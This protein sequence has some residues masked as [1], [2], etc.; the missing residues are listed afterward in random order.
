MAHH[1]CR[2]L[3]DPDGKCRLQIGIH[4]SP[5]SHVISSSDSITKRGSQKTCVVGRTGSI[6]TQEG[7]IP[8]QSS[9][10]SSRFFGDFLFSSQKDGRMAPNYKPEASQ[11]FY[12]AQTFP[13]GDFS[14]CPQVANQKYLGDFHRPP[15]R[16]FTHPYS[17]TT[18]EVASFHDLR[19]GLR[20]PLSPFWS[21][22][23]PQSFHKGGHVHSSLSPEAGGVNSCLPRRLVDYRSHLS[24]GGAAHQ[25]GHTNDGALGVH[26]EQ[27][28]VSLR[29]HAVS[30]VSGSSSRLSLRPRNTVAGES[31]QTADVGTVAYP[32]SLGD[33]VHMASS[34]G[35]HGQYGRYCSLL[36][37]THETD[38]VAPEL[39]LSTLRSRD[40]AFG[41]HVYS[42]QQGAG[43]VDRS[44]QSVGRYDLSSSTT[45]VGVNNRRFPVRLGGARGVT[46]SERSMGRSAQAVAHKRLG[47]PGSVKFT[48][49]VLSVG[50]RKANFDSDR[51]CNDGS[52][53]QSPRRDTFA[54]ALS[55]STKTV[56]M[57]HRQ[58]GVNFRGTHSRGRQCPGGQFVSRIHPP[59]NGVVAISV[60]RG[61]DFRHNMA[62]KRG[63]FCNH[64]QSQVASLL[65]KDGRQPS[66]SNRCT[67][68]QLARVGGVRVSPHISITS[69]SRKDIEGNVCSP[70]NSP[71]LA[72]AAVVST[73][74][75][76]SGG[77]AEVA[78]CSSRSAVNASVQGQVPRRRGSSFNCLAAIKRR[79]RKAGF[80][81]RSA[82]FVA[83]GRREST[84]KIYA[85]RLRPYVEWCRRKRVSPNSTSVAQVADF[86]CTV[87]DKG[88]LALT[89]RGYLS[90]I[91]SIHE[92]T[93]DGSSLRDSD[94]LRLLIEGMHNSAPPRRKI[95]PSW[96]LDLVL[97]ALNKLPYEPIL[98]A[99]LRDVTIKTAFLLAIASG[100]RASEIHALAINE[101]M[102]FSRHGVTLYFRP[103]F[104]AKN[105]KSNFS[106]S[107]ISLPKLDSSA[108]DRRLSCPVRALK[109]YLCK[110]QS[111]R[112]Q[113]NQLFITS[114]KPYKP[115]ARTTIAGWVVEA[116]TKSN[117]VSGKGRPTAHSTRSMATTTALHKGLSISEIIH[118]VSWKSDS[119]FIST[120]LKDKPPTSG[121][122]RFA[123]SVL[124]TAQL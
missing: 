79:Y 107:P 2:Q 76:P 89:V 96:D 20:L 17:S 112:G 93:P 50:S 82:S 55:S 34:S 116:I 100:R 94:A 21:V 22:D 106:A 88:V 31:V 120:Y 8:S 46:S 108:G 5:S 4:G 65:L 43:V 85:A 12:Q 58:R 117:A 25:F 111:V 54:Y 71:L 48:Q 41:T 30:S 1:W 18:S 40:L 11:R 121:S 105:E 27:S 84:L 7:S 23:G 115:A 6:A 14:H 35:S 45:S 104:L 15:G 59:S 90:A 80:S 57:V 78:S 118:T 87:F 73:A 44:E 33:G 110:T 66:T 103:S 92:G 37:A 16:I 122:T 63:S 77:S 24:V 52:L 13:Y 68:D 67:V 123:T 38:S 53:H 47:T 91:L 28:K 70:V 101:H 49:R 102:I 29:A 72:K 32:L 26:S 119:V 9:S 39:P 124:T 60:S 99:S 109:W 19:P 64:E 36:Q 75:A 98:S 10:V 114:N 113:S 61:K 74:A 42:G 56:S 62:S 83:Q 69:S 3:G 97:E 81:V 86:L 95:W 51:Q